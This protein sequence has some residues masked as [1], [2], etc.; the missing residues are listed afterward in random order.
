MRYAGLIKNDIAAAPGLCVTFF[1]QGCPIHCPG[2]HNPEAQDPN[3]GTPFTD[4]TIDEI[5]AAIGAN[6]IQR[7]LCIMGG[8]PFYRDNP[9]E[10]LRLINKVVDTYSNIKIYV[11]TGYTYE[12]L[13]QRPSYTISMILQSIDYLI[14]GPYIQEERD[15]TL[16]MRGSKNQRILRLR[17]GKIMV[18]LP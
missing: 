11:W 14:D 3:Y 7:K 8:E 17:N 6:G 12:E 10:V 15:I 5:I 16:K 18:E 1:V 9:E 2:C 4:D 13:Y